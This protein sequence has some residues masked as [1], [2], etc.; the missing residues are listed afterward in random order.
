MIIFQI[1]NED[2]PNWGRDP[3]PLRLDPQEGRSSWSQIVKKKIENIFFLSN[4][5]SVLF[6]ESE[7]E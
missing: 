1:R 4:F 6:P 3:H 5:F 7:V 2:W